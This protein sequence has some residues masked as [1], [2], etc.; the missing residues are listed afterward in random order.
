MLGRTPPASAGS[1]CLIKTDIDSV[2]ICQATSTMSTSPPSSGVQRSRCSYLTRAAYFFRCRVP[3]PRPLRL[4]RHTT[5]YSGGCGFNSR[6]SS[7]VQS[8]LRPS[9]CAHSKR[10]VQVKF[11]P[12]VVA[13]VS[14][15]DA[16]TFGRVFADTRSCT[17]IRFVPNHNHWPMQKPWLAERLAIVYYIEHKLQYRYWG[18]RENLQAR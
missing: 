9:D 7:P 6:N 15:P 4:W 5:E 1:A 14:I 16:P 2:T 11:Y 18:V 10:L 12:Q 8:L 17:K 3:N 13:S